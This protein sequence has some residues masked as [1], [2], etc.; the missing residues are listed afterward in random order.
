MCQKY[1]DEFLYL[2]NEGYIE[3]LDYS[4]QV[5]DIL[6]LEVKTVKLDN[7]TRKTTPKTLQLKIGTKYSV[8][9]ST[10]LPFQSCIYF[11][12]F[13][14]QL[15]ASHYLKPNL[16]SEAYWP[17]AKIRF[18]THRCKF[19]IH[20]IEIKNVYFHVLSFNQDLSS[21]PSLIG[22]TCVLL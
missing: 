6:I 5:L 3:R 16:L 21:I 9:L 7:F 13:Q 15:Q 14:H 4:R 2:D 12:V 11:I 22:R 17:I 1:K 19:L 20:L 18:M 10:L 8:T